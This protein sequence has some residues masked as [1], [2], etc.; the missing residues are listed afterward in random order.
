[1]G[2]RGRRSPMF[3]SA[4]ALLALSACNP[5]RGPSPAPVAVADGAGS[6]E[7]DAAQRP[8]V[9]TWPV[10][11]AVLQ[12]SVWDADTAR[13]RA[14]MEAARAV[15]FRA[16]SAFSP[17][18]AAWN[19][20]GRDTAF[21]LSAATMQ[22]MDFHRSVTKASGR[23]L[24][25]DLGGMAKGLALDR[26]LT[27]LR[28]GGV[29][30][31]VADLGGTFTVF[32]EA[33]MGPR[34][35]MA[36]ENPFHPGEVFAA[37]QLDSG[38]VATWSD[39]AEPRISRPG[40]TVVSVSVISGGAFISVTLSR[41]FFALGPE[42]GCRLAARFP[43]VDAVWVREPGAAEREELERDADD[44]V[45][46]ELVVITDALADRL[47]LLSEEPTDERPTRCSALVRQR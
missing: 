15:V 36:L 39:D 13:A 19:A 24:E 26:A 7:G 5:P 40:R 9:R 16:D 17:E 46:P 12:V 45:D 27:A 1:M 6:F 22:L 41:A 32:G 3:W 20:A 33:P 10:M 25:A 23:A 38:A 42:A 47:E 30:S 14:A 44:G 31:G 43:G 35:S 2:M 21:A 29:R 37:L 34:W 4:A 11:G 8:V 28:T 18:I